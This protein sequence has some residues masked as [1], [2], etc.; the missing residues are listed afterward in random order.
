MQGICTTSRGSRFTCAVPTA[1]QFVIL[2]FVTLKYPISTYFYAAFVIFALL[3]LVELF[4]F[5]KSA[6]TT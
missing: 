4:Q 5:K 2:V 6:S 1:L 3:A